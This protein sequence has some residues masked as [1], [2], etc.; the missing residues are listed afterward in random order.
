MELTTGTTIREI[1]GN[2][3]R[4][5]AV[6]EKH[7]IDFCCGG[8]RTLD[9]AC[10]QKGV[11]PALMIR[12]LQ[13]VQ[14]PGD[15]LAFRPNEWDLDVL[16]DFIVNNHHQY[17][18]RALPQILPHLEKLVSVHGRNHSELYDIAD[19]FRVVA[20]G[21]T[22]HMQKEE[23]VLFPYIRNLAAVSKTGGAPIRP[24][25]STVRRPIAMMEAEHASSGEALAF[26]RRVTGGY[27]PPPDACETY[28]VTLRELEEFEKDLHQHVHLEN[29]ILFPRAIALEDEISSRTNE[30]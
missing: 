30:G 17:V 23:I 14:G 8:D 6:F 19:R 7:S 26:I 16:A 5:A 20:D 24:A 15:A 27:I 2:N 18:R 21:L 11:D 3:H 4:A 22:H 1:V 9:S 13:E 29:N 12:E 10:A 28:R 25:F